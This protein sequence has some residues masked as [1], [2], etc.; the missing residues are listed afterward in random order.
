MT[1]PAPCDRD[2]LAQAPETPDL[3]SCC[4][5]GCEPCIFD[6]HDMAMDRN[7][8]ELLPRPQA[9]MFKGAPHW[10]QAGNTVGS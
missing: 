2:P 4:G 9:T 10:R 5:N 3:D 6:L 1:S 8:Q 7:R